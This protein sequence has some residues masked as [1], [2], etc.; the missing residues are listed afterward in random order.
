MFCLVLVRSEPVGGVVW[1][2]LSPAGEYHSNT[3]LAV[4][5]STKGTGFPFSPAP[6]FFWGRCFVHLVQRL[7]SA[8]CVSDFLFCSVMVTPLPFALSVSI[9]PGGRKAMIAVWTLLSS[10]FSSSILVINFGDNRRP[11]RYDRLQVSC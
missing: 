4:D 2:V 7:P 3:T 5:E 6:E 9:L 8:P 11:Y 1:S 10:F